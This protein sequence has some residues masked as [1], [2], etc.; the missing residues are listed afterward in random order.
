MARPEWWDFELSFTSHVEN[1]MEERGFS[2]VELRAMLENAGKLEPARR[3]GRWIVRTRHAG[4]AWA[5]VV[6]PDEQERTLV[7]VTAYPVDLP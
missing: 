7:I 4:G 6:E 3:G 2:E 1:R 5:V